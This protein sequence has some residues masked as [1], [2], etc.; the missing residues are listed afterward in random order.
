MRGKP[1]RGFYT[2]EELKKHK[3][4]KDYVSKKMAG[5][6]ALKDYEQ[7][8]SNRIPSHL[9]YYG[10]K[11]WKR[12]MPLL[13]KLPVAEL[14][15]EL[16]ESYCSLHGSRR[17]LEKDIQKYGESLKFYDNEGNLENV[18]RNPSYD[19]LLQTIKEIRMIANQLGMTM[20]SR[21]ELVVPEEDEEEDEVLKLLKG[22]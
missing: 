5:Q 13:G 10:K 3:K 20:N 6:E 14:D 4:G 2:E 16:I 17:R 11:E 8:E 19:M 18:R 21:L 12:I 7:L 22:G 9:C 1:S 15:R